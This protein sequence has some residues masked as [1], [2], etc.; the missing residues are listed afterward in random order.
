[1]NITKVRQTLAEAIMLIEGE[2]YAALA[3][4]L[5]REED[6]EDEI[7]DQPDAESPAEAQHV[8]PRRPRLAEQG[9]GE[10]SPPAVESFLDYLTEVGLAATELAGW[11]DVSEDDAM[12]LVLDLVDELVSTGDLPAIPDID[13]AGEEDLSAWITA[14]E[15]VGLRNLLAVV[16]SSEDMAE[17]KRGKKPKALIKLMQKI[18]AAWDKSKKTQRNEF[19]FSNFSQPDL[20]AALAEVEAELDQTGDADTKSKLAAIKTALLPDVIS[21]PYAERK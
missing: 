2:R 17:S 11:E 8:A 12:D 18:N 19:H 7:C 4:D 15:E 20:E 13:T 3:K 5:L 14:A 1:M 9:E 21:V 6:E 16:L 10:K